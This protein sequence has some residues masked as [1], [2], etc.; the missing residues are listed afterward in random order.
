MS[1][2]RNVW[3]QRLQNADPEVRRDAIRQLETIG[4]VTALGPLATVFATDPDSSLR[5]LARQAGKTIY[6]A[7]INRASESPRGSQSDRQQAADILAKAH[8]R[9]QQRRR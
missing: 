1:E 2:Q 3:I 5:A 7:A 8:A 9:K 4:E 6:Y